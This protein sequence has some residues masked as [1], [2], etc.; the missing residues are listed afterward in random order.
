[1]MEPGKCGIYMDFNGISWILVEF[2]GDLME[3]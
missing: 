2:S 1:M 3:F